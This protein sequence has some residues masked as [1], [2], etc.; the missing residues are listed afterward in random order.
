MNISQAELSKAAAKSGITPEQTNLLWQELQAN[1]PVESAVK[2]KFDITHVTYYAGAL[3]VIGAMGCFMGLGWES[4]GG[5]GIFIIAAIYGLCFVLAGRTLW[6]QNLNIP[7]GLLFTMAVGMVPLATYGL[8]RLTNFWPDRDP[9]A[10]VNFHPYINGSWIFM[11]AAT[12]VTGLIFLRFWRFPF[13]TAPI[14]FALWFMSMDLVALLGD[15]HDMD[16]RQKQI[17]SAVFGGVMILVA[18]LIDLRGRANDYAFWGYLFGLMAFW[19]GLST[20]DSDSS[21][22]KFIY[23]LIN[24]GLIFCALV[25][26]RRAF[27]IFGSLGVCGY[28]GYLAYSV[29][30]NSLMFPFILSLVGIGIIYLGVQYQ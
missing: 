10:Y 20:M 19:G 14:A 26:R 24:L 16:W 7:G 9:G 8:E 27:I 29:F 25:L 18:Y 22:N 23:F 6:K 11:E 17:V 15:H 21:L 3:I 13:L 4:F 5:G 28:L 2:P 1:Q 30:E 12:V